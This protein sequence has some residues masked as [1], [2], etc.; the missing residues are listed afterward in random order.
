MLERARHVAPLQTN[1][2]VDPPVECPLVCRRPSLSLYF[3]NIN[4]KQS[5]RQKTP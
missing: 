1:A 4:K 2:I 5:G 3:A